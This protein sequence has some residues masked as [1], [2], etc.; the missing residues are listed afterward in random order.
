MNHVLV[1]GANGFVGSR[2][3]SLLQ[4]KGYRVTQVVRDAN[5]VNSSFLKDGMRDDN[6]IISIGN[7][8]GCTDWSR[9]MDG[10]DS[11]VHLA[12]RVHVMREKSR[13]P[14]ESFRSVNVAGTEQLARAAI[15]HG[16]R[17]F[18]YISS[19]SVHGNST[20]DRAYTEDDEAQPHSSYAISK[21][22]G[23]LALRSVAAG[24]GLE[25]VI[26]RPPLV[27]GSG[28]G[29]NFLRLMCL[30]SRGW[31]LP[32]G[33]IKNLR[34]FV[35]VE[36][37]ADMIYRCVVNDRIAGESF[38]VCDG[39][40]LSTPD[41]VRRIAQ[42]M[43]RSARLFPCSVSMMRGAA[44]FSKKEDVLD[45]LCNSLRVNASK[46]RCLLDW[47]PQISLDDGLARTVKWYVETSGI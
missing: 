4:K 26:V 16:V 31:P 9:A 5:R 11:I 36:N 15:A 13:N 8:D 14:L 23:E 29:G 25:I 20:D 46:A 39:E 37:L 3:C 34:S 7:I 17:R 43:G 2:V 45:R 32:F 33:S 27:Y 6:R 28:V 10:V 24:T 47:K 42:L 35:G 18:V 22:E 30:V 38:V 1:T 21:W 40:D 19:I 12:A 41:L 44:R